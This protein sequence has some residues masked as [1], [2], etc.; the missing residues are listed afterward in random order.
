MKRSLGLTVI[1]VV[2]AFAAGALWS[3]AP[4]K[5]E[6]PHSLVSIYHIAP[7][8]HRAFLKWMADRDALDTQAGVA[9]AQWYTHTDGDSWDYVAV[10]P[11]NTDAQDAKLD[12][13]AAK[14][15]LTTGFAASLEFRTLVAS[16]T[17]TFTIG[18][19]TASELSAM[20]G[21]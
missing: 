20:A 14:K 9:N 5:K 10:G 13:L 12:E 11:V 16:H 21:K 4:A 7:G 6:P 18:P 19:V 15:G 1:A 3:Q 8:Q 17:D 2:L